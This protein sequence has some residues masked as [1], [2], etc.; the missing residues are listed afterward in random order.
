MKLLLFCI[1][2]LPCG[3]FA[4][5]ANKWY[6]DQMYNAFL[7]QSIGET[8]LS[9]RI[10]KNAYQGA[11]QAGESMAKLKV[12]NEIFVW[13]RTYGWSCRVMARPANCQGEYYCHSSDEND[14][15][16]AN[17]PKEDYQYESEWG[18]NPDQA[19]H[20]RQFVFGIAEVIS[21]IFIVTVGRV[22]PQ[23]FGWGLIGGGISHMV[24]SLNTEWAEQEKRTLE[25]KQIEHRAYEATK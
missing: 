14:T 4:G 18:K 8:R 13:Y 15:Y 17:I 23:S 7:I 6:T 5:S 21:G 25:L 10:F 19:K 9:Y 24:T 1:F 22:I 16:D 2:L 20:I 11:Q 12:M 3:C